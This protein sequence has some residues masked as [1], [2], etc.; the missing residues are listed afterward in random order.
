MHAYYEDLIRFVRQGWDTAATGFGAHTGITPAA[1]PPPPLLEHLLSTCY[2]ASLL[3]EEERPVRVRLMVAA[4][5]LFL[6]ADSPP[7]GLHRQVFSQSRPCDE[8][9][10]RKLSPAVDFSR[11]LIGVTLDAHRQWQIWGIVHS[12]PRWLQAYRGGRQV[13]PAFPDVPVILVNGPGRLAM[14]R[15]LETLATL[16]EGRI[17]T[18]DINVF[19]AGWIREYFSGLRTEMLEYLAASRDGGQKWHNLLDPNLIGIMGKHATMR[20]ISTMRESRQGG[21]LLYLPHDRLEEFTAKNPFITVKYQFQEDATRQRLVKLILQT[22][23]ILTRLS[24]HETDS[25]KK[26]GWQEY[27]ASNSDSLSLFEEAIFETAHQLADFAA[28]D[29]AVVFTNRSRMLGFGGMIKGDFDQVDTVARALDPEGE[30]LV[31]EP[32]ENVG[33]RHRSVYSL[34]HRIPEALGI[35]ISQDGNVRFIKRHNGRVTYWEQAISFALK[36]S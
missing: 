2:Q 3:R 33:T 24:S 35:V 21:T 19:E 9:E 6:E 8:T 11:S 15:G 7:P 28:V 22:L 12:G 4:P 34:C 17:I 26:L 25:G 29:G 13:P 31:A 16:V 32:T 20:I 10:L 30:Q 14:L 18:P 5:G 1:L 36:I 27:V 23:Q